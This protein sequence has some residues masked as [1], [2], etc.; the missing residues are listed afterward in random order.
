VGIVAGCGG[1]PSADN[2]FDVV[3]AGQEV[4]VGG[5]TAAPATCQ[6]ECPPGLPPKR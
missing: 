4:H 6:T 5:A 3:D 2:S 1:Q